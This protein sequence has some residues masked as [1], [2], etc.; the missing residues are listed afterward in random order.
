LN[1]SAS[2]KLLVSATSLA[3][4][5]LL[6]EGTMSG[7]TLLTMAVANVL[8]GAGDKWRWLTAPDLCAG[9]SSAWSVADSE[10]RFDAFLR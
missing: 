3:A 9:C 7:G 6:P 1:A 10:N 8:G 5:G 2:A 4:L